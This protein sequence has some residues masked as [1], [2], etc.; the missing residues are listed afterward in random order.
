METIKSGLV[1]VGLIQDPPKIPVV[2]KQTWQNDVLMRSIKMLDIGYIFA[3]YF[4]IAIS[5]AI[6]ID[7]IMG[8]FDPTLYKDIPN[9]KIMLELL[10][11][12]WMYGVACY[13]IRNVVELIPFP[14]D[15]YGGFKHK[16][17]KELGS[18]WVFGFVFLTCSSY[19]SER[20]R[21]FYRRYMTGEK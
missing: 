19:M 16:K 13:I 4:I 6:I 5:L 2:P 21:Y 1:A 17:V 10:F 11:A 14:L 12:F 18:A 3:I 7:K 9:W 8:P 20:L 15:G